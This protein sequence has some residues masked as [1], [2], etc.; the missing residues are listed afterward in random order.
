M[1]ASTDIKFYVHTNT[2][3]PQLQNVYGSIIAILDACLINGFGSQT[4]SSLTSNEKTITATFGT[5]HNFMQYQV[6]NISGADQAEFNGVHRITSVPTN[7][8]FTFELAAAP[9][10]PTATGTISCSLP[11]LG[12][13]KPFSSS[14]KAAYRSTNNLL[15]SRPFLRVVD[16]LDPSYS[17]NFAKYAKVGIVE[18]M[19]DIN[20]MVG[21]QAPFDSNNPNK[22]WIATG[23]GTSVVN[24]WAKWYYANFNPFST[25]PVHDIGSPS[26]GNRKWIIVGNTDYFY[27]LPCTTTTDIYAHTYGFGSFKSLINNDTSNNFLAA[28]NYYGAAEDYVLRGL[29][30]ALGGTGNE[31]AVFLQR[32]FSQSAQ[33]TKGTTKSLKPDQMNTGDFY[34]GTLNYIGAYS[35]TNIAPF[36]PVFI[37]ENVL[38]GELNGFYWLFQDKPYPDLSLIE[39][40]NALYIAASTTC[41]TRPGQVILKVG[42]L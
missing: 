8:T 16:E 29:T 40:S 22:N 37:T 1:V 28:T 26:D 19:T 13:E 32:G 3:A 12:W 10:A 27:I 11:P 31:Q 30:L 36:A 24:G 38:R 35:L 9:S 2:N 25:G 17:P 42:D 4:I 6:V 18:D 41:G 20:T 5:S 7:N 33:S 39:K 15:A 14:G 23:S 21:V 34:S